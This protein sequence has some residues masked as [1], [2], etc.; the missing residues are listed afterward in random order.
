MSHR[1]EFG[2]ILPEVQKAV[3]VEPVHMQRGITC[4]KRTPN[5]PFLLRF[6][7]NFIP[8]FDLCPE[9]VGEIVFEIR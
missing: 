6:Y 1:V 3:G 5:A 9:N 4:I 8:S 7:F 2:K